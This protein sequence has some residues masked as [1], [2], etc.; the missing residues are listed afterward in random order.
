MFMYANKHEFVYGVKK[1]NTYFFNNLQYPHMHHVHF[2]IFKTKK[3]IPS[4]F[5]IPV[6]SNSLCKCTNYLNCPYPQMKWYSLCFL[7]QW[8]DSNSKS[9]YCCLLWGLAFLSDLTWGLDYNIIK[10]SRNLQWMDVYYHRFTV[11]GLENVIFFFIIYY[12]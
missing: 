9:I 6:L 11:F 1:Q 7:T 3:L 2:K 10:S 5:Q 12:Q 4:R 8:N